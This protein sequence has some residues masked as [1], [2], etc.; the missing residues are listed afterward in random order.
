MAQRS[1]AVGRTSGAD[2]YPYDPSLRAG[3]LQGLDRLRAIADR[4]L[5]AYLYVLYTQ[6]YGNSGEGLERRA[7]HSVTLDALRRVAV[8]ALCGELG[9]DAHEL[10]T[11]LLLDQAGRQCLDEAPLREFADRFRELR[12]DSR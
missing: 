1:Q 12:R 8:R 9:P 2:D 5:A 3:A 10:A 7:G 6:A 11:Y 4:K